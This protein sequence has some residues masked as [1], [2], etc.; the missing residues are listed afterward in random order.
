MEAD[1]ISERYQR[2]EQAVYEFIEVS[3]VGADAQKAQ[4]ESNEKLY[5]EEALKKQIAILQK[6]L[7]DMHPESVTDVRKFEKKIQEA[8]MNETAPKRGGEG[9][10]PH[11]AG[12]REQPR[13][14]HAV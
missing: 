3:K 9:L 4:T 7:D 12:G 8:G 10:K 6:E 1:R 2:I 13:I 11:E 5:R 14:W